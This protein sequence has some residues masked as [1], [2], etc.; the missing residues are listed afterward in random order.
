MPHTLI[1][2]TFSW[3]CPFNLLWSIKYIFQIKNTSYHLFSEPRLNDKISTRFE[4]KVWTQRVK[5]SLL[6]GAY[7]KSNAHGSVKKV[8]ELHITAELLNLNFSSWNLAGVK[9][10][11]EI[12]SANAVS[13]MF[14]LSFTMDLLNNYLRP[15]FAPSRP[16]YGYLRLRIFHGQSFFKTAT[17]EERGR[18]DGHL[19]TLFFTQK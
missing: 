9:K 6:T 18:D 19:A 3:D 13:I 14:S 7:H 4:K 17:F 12:C 5:C 8:A 10:N 16:F 11:S 1:S 15:H 2:P